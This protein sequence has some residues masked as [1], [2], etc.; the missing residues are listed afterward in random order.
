[1]PIINVTTWS[2]L[3]DDRS[4][5]LIEALTNTVRNVTGA[6]LDKIT[7]YITE[8]PTNR[9]GEAGVLGSN[10]E[11]PVLSRRQA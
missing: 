6:P 4:R 11:F 2:T 10:S 8:I 3:G 5:E 7:V 9:W 1:M